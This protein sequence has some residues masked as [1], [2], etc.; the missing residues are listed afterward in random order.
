M[1]CSDSFQQRLF[2]ITKENFEASA[3]E[4]FDYQ[5]SQ[6]EA[7][8]SY[9]KYLKKTPKKVKNIKQIPFL[10]IEFFKNHAIKSGKWETTHLFK[11]SGT[12][13]TGRSHHHVKDVLFYRQVT[14]AIYQQFFGTLDDTTI[15]AL[16]PSYQEQGNSSLIEMID[17][18]IR[19]AAPGSGYFP[20]NQRQLAPLLS[21]PQK[22]WIIGVSYALLD[23]IEPKRLSVGNMTIMETGGMKGRKKEMT[24]FELH[25]IL[26]KRLRTGYNIFRIWNDGTHEPGIWKRRGF[27][28]SCMGKSPY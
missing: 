20:N 17:H 6:C 22:K 5:Y 16:L 27:P 12:T 18:F 24:R 7:Y 2:N 3:L 4:L 1:N 26:K 15:I 19:M 10:P 14:Y 25:S 8:G 23:L 28:V 13:A 21:S 9:C 11:S